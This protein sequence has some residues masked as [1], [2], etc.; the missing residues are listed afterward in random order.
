MNKLEKML[1]NYVSKYND[2]KY[3]KMKFAIQNNEVSNLKKYY[4]LYKM[5]KMEGF[6]NAS[7]GNRINGGSYFEEKPFLPHGI[8]GIFITDSSKRGKNCTILHQVT[9]GLK[10]FKGTKGPIIGDNVFIGAGAKIIGP[11]TIGNN[12][13]IGANAVICEDIPDNTTV[14]PQ[15][16][17]IITRSKKK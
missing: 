1:N 2:E 12:V 9:I 13:R 17:R 6:N 7:L 16:S 10:D 3:W 11:I 4:Y 15:K 5:K 8:K 14:V